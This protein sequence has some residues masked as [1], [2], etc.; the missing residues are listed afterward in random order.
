MDASLDKSQFAYLKGKGVR[1]AIAKACEHLDRAKELRELDQRSPHHAA[2]RS[3]KPKL[4]GALTLTLDL[5]KAF[6]SVTRQELI[7]ALQHLQ[8]DTETIEMVIQLHSS[9]SYSMGRNGQTSTVQTTSGI[10]QGCKAAPVLWTSLTLAL[11]DRIATRWGTDSK[12]VALALTVFADDFLY[13]GILRN[14]TQLE[15]SL[16][17]MVHLFQVLAE[18]GLEI[19]SEKSVVLM[20]VHGSQ[21]GIVRERHTARKDKKLFLKLPNGIRIQVKQ[22]FTYLGVKLSYGSYKDQTVSYRLEQSKSK[23]DTLHRTLRSTRV[24]SLRKRLEIWRSH[25][26]SSMLYGLSSTGVTENGL[27]RL[28]KR[29][30]ANLRSFMSRHQFLERET[31]EHL[32]ESL[33]VSDLQVVLLE[34]ISTFLHV[35]EGQPST[36]IQQ[37]S[38]LAERLL[39]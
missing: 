21:Q 23:F 16:D 4:V 29:Y 15:L 30:S 2:A 38:G 17:R 36:T 1:E 33:G 27:N 13:Q 26:E 11:L 25:V 3:N 39:I 32:F 8:V 22:S 5:S 14:W 6:D 34:Q 9:T 12:Q 20:T 31:T 18:A 10:K 7:L 24:L 19:N 35:I 37:M 28:V